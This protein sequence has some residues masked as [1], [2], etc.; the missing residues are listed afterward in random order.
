MREGLVL[1]PPASIA[2]IRGG[3]RLNVTAARGDHQVRILTWPGAM[4]PFLERWVDEQ[5]T[6]TD[7]PPRAVACRPIA[8]QFSSACDRLQSAIAGPPRSVLPLVTSVIY[9]VAALLLSEADSVKLAGLPR[10]LPPTL[11][12]LTRIVRQ[13]PSAPWPLKEAADFAGYSA[14]YFSRVFKQTIGYGFH[15]YVDRSRTERAVE[16][17]CT[18]NASVELVASSCGYGTT[19]GLRDSVREYLGVV[20]S[21]LRALAINES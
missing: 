13:D 15:E 14:F 18:T 1:A 12:S 2:F 10:D 17:L 9:E 8:P 21:E 5:T 11:E 7:G 19:Q 16:M 20:P 6:V 4:L 3:I